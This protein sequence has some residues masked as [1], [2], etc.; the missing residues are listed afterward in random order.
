MLN[1]LVVYV[2]SK[3]YTTNTAKSEVVHFNS[4]RV[5]QVPH[6]MLA[7]AAS[8][9]SESLMYLGVTFRWTMESDHA[10]TPMLASAHQYRTCGFV[11]DNV[12]YDR[13]LLPFGWLR[14]IYSSYM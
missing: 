13:F 1:R 6:F 7:G 10:V 4:K 9:C 8:K 14:Q 3:H 5:A 2:R 11:Q 12:L